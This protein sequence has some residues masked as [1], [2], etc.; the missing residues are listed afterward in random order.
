MRR[1][2]TMG[3]IVALLLGVIGPAASA[4]DQRHDETGVQTM[5]L[6]SQE[7][8]FTFVTATGEVF[9]D[10][11][12]PEPGT[13]EPFAGPGDRFLLVDTLFSDPERTLEVG[14]NLVQCTF[15]TATGETEEEFTADGLCHGVVTLDSQGDLAWQGQFRI[16]ESFTEEGPIITVAIT[17]GTAA[18]ERAGGSAAIFDESPEGDESLARY[19][20][21]LL[22]FKV[23]PGKPSV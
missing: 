14:R 20:I 10:G 21:R 13:P 23:H 4:G 2:L 19:E 16:P 11:A 12:E 6:F 8:S 22:T 15:V 9:A 5:T 18:F 7:T 1:M 17:G 3:A